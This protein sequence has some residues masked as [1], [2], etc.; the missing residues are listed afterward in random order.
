MEE[1]SPGLAEQEERLSCSFL[2]TA[3]VQQAPSCKQLAS[4]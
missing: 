4:A 1:T 3:L 2:N